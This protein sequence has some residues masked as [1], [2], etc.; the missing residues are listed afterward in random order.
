MLVACA[1]AV[2]EEGVDVIIECFVIE[3]KFGEEAQV[4]APGALAPA[5]DFKKGDMV[6]TVN[7][8]A[9][10]MDKRALRSVS[11]ERFL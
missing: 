6:V 1:H 2:E 4:P 10:R 9:R 11:F 7:F 5:V 3:E 8:V